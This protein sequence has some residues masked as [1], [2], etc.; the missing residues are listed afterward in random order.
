MDVETRDRVYDELT[1][2]IG[3]RLIEA[4]TPI[5][6][7]DVEVLATDRERDAGTSPAAALGRLIVDCGNLRAIQAA[8]ISQEDAIRSTMA[9][10]AT[11]RIGLDEL[12]R[13]GIDEGHAR[14]T[15]MVAYVAHDHALM[16]TAYRAI[17]RAT[18]LPR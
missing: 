14:R 2:T 18:E 1:T 16:L 8:I 13:R 12:Q 17:G 5:A 9:M 11:G 15:L 4:G 3:N 6:A 10:S 7:A